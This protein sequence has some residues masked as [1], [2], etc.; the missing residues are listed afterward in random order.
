MEDTSSYLNCPAIEVTEHIRDDHMNMCRFAR[1]DDAEY[2]KVAMALQRMAQLVPTPPK[3]EE[4]GSLTDEQRQ[5]LLD[6]M[7]FDQIGARQMNIGRAHAK[8]CEWILSKSEYRE[9][10]DAGKVQE[11]HGFL[12]IKG[13][14]GTGKSTIMKFALT[15]SQRSMKKRIFVSF[16]FNARGVDLEKST[17]GM[18]R[19][20]LVQLLERIPGLSSIF[21]SLGFTTW[22]ISGSHEWSVEKLKN[23]SEQAIEKLGQAC[24]ICFIDALDECDESQIRDMVTFFQ[25]LG[26][27]ASSK[28]TR[29]QV[30]FSSRHYPHITIKRGLSLVLEGQSGHAED[31][32]SYIQSNL[33]IG[34]TKLAEQIRIELQEKAS[35]VFMWVVLVVDILNKEFDDG[36]IHALRK[37]LRDIPDD[38]HELFRDLLT[39]DSHNRSELL[40]CIQWILFSKS[41]LKPEELYFAILSGVEP[42]SLSSW[43]PHEI[44]VETINRFILNSSKGLAEATRTDHS[45][46]QFIH[47]SVKDFLLKENG[48]RLAWPELGSNVEGQSHERLKQCCLNYIDV[49]SHH[50]DIDT[51]QKA[52]SKEAVAARELASISFPFFEYSVQNIW[53]H[54]NIAQG[55]GFNQNN[56]LQEFDIAH[57]IRLHNFLERH[58]IRRRT[59]DASLLYILS[60]KNAAN[61]IEKHLSHESCFKVEAERYGMPIL[62]AR[63]TGSHEAFETLLR[64]HVKRQPM[65][66]SSL[67]DAW[68]LHIQNGKKPVE[69]SRNFQFSTKAKT[70]HYVAVNGDKLLL[71][72]LLEDKGYASELESKDSNGDTPLLLA[73]RKGHDA[74]CKILLELGANIHATNY[75]GKTPLL[76]AAS[77]GHMLVCRVLL[78]TGALLQWKDTSPLTSL[79][80][81]ARNGY[82]A[83]C[84]LLLDAGISIETRDDS[85]HTPLLSAALSGKEA[86]VKLLLD[87]GADTQVMDRNGRTPLSLASY[88]GNKT[89]VKLLLDAEAN[90]EAKDNIGYTPL[91]LATSQGY[92]NVVKC[93][94]D[95]GA[96]IESRDNEG[97]TPLSHAVHGHW[98]YGI[99]GLLLERGAN[100][101]A[102]DNGGRTPLSYTVGTP[103]EWRFA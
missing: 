24:V 99:V 44:S 90:I 59:L 95:A 61:L 39:R 51:S 77:F 49:E 101:T 93:L 5:T 76:Y 34:R 7:K 16:F 60:E 17:V 10:L 2:M 19:S 55:D 52:S 35:G 102:R 43:D 40:L 82:D 78:E 63:A 30:C 22:N 65:N 20:L 57:W 31:I 89:V 86:V 97:L 88:Y 14:P 58:D 98:D 56:F 8:T 15:H 70:L 38:L 42:Q 87:E 1:L 6:S 92:N 81:A 103:Y 64:L 67:H 69:Y 84:K 100:P 25:H 36:R 27:V 72:F 71:T 47:E 53:H 68:H 33:E 46:V 11:H 50:L 3:L 28:G 18:Y 75:S 48:L 91:T 73:A 41:P 54:T 23:L 96:D 32:T 85:Y 9:W 13:K 12:W 29:F 21:D 37:R 80:E 79:H 66:Y 94:L 62:A 4:A 45:T 74:A 26:E 83:I